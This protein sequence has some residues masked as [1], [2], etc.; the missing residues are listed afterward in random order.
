MEADDFVIRNLTDQID[1]FS[2]IASIINDQLAALP[3][4]EREH[5]ED[6]SRILRRARAAEGRKLL[7]LS[8]TQGHEAD[9]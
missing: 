9:S 7:P 1:A 5:I 6:A 8:V 4:Q 3:D 2:G